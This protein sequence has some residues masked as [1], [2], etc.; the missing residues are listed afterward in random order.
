M[1]IVFI[2]L[3][4]VNYLEFANTFGAFWHYSDIY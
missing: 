3:Q 4:H 2:S 1:Y